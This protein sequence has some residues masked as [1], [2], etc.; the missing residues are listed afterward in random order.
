MSMTQ[1]PPGLR[2]Q[3]TLKL[4]IKCSCHLS[5]IIGHHSA[6][7]CQC[8]SQ[9]NGTVLQSQSVYTQVWPHLL[10]LTTYNHL[11]FFFFTYLQNI[12]RENILENYCPALASNLNRFDFLHLQQQ[13]QQQKRKAW[14]FVSPGQPCDPHR[15]HAIE[16][17]PSTIHS[18][19][20]VEEFRAGLLVQGS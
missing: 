7:F 19:I 10:F 12:G 1:Y 3:I 13:Q 5:T 15:N 16:T 2:D 11:H 20:L 9:S 17:W 6:S 18:F 14:G 8:H 4:A